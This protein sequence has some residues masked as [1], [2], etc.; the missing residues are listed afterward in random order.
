M[1]TKSI[2]AQALANEPQKLVAIYN[3]GGRKRIAQFTLNL[4]GESDGTNL[5]VTHLPPAAVITRIELYQDGSDAQ[6]YNLGDANDEDGLIDGQAIDQTLTV[7]MANQNGGTNGMG[8]ADFQKQLWEVLGYS[9][10]VQ[11]GG[12]I[13]LWLTPSGGAAA[14]GNTVYGSIEYIVD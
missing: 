14:D 11:S 12:N 4:E 2:Q 1:A 10:R 3:L 13:R 6:A 5:E 8:P 7:S 9:S